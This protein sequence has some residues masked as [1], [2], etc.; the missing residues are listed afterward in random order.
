MEAALKAQEEEGIE[1]GSQPVEAPKD[2]V[3]ALH[4]ASLRGY[5]DTVELLVNEGQAD[6]LAEDQEEFSALKNAVQGN[7]GEVATFL[8]EHGAN[9]NDVYVDD[10]GREHN[11]LM[12]AL[13]VENENFAQLLISHQANVDYTD[14]HGV[15]TLIQASHKGLKDVVTSLLEL[16]K[17][18]KD[19]RT[20][21]VEATTE[22]AC[23]S[24]G[25]MTISM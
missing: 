10:E 18:D 14:A 20:V 4:I 12:D 21:D 9:P 5:L 17:N 24:L 3:T 15:T 2:G 23:G 7:H 11:L 6:I 25:Q 13:I 8:I 16:N 22:E 1:N 19:P